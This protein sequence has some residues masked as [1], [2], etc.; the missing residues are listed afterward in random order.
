MT[1]TTPTAAQV[2]ATARA[3]LRDHLAP[4]PSSDRAAECAALEAIAEW[5]EAGHDL[6]AQRDRG[7]DHEH[8]DNVSDAEEWAT[9]YPASF[10]E[11]VREF[12]AEFGADTLDLEKNP[13][14][15]GRLEDCARYWVQRAAWDR[16]AAAVEEAAAG[17][18][19]NR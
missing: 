10:R 14:P 4:D 9:R 16:M 5:A 13:D 8:A 1:E 7:A 18:E 2:A 15:V 12:V 19:D 3:M 6:E 11:A 17:Q